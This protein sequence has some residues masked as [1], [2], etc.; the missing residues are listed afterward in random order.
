MGPEQGCLW[1][2][3]LEGNSFWERLEAPTPKESEF[4]GSEE[5]FRHTKATL[6]AQMGKLR[7]PAGLWLIQCRTPSTVL[8]S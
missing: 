7:H 8:F 1:T 4:V 2:A 5:A 6:V 3:S